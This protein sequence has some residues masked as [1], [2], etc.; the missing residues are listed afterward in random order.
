LSCVG[1]VLDE[2]EVFRKVLGDLL[3][4]LIMRTLGAF[5]I[6]SLVMLL[7]C[8]DGAR[9]EKG[10]AWKDDL[11][12]SIEAFKNRKIYQRLTPEILVSIPDHEL[13]LAIVDYVH[14]KVGRRYDQELQIVGRM[15]E[16]IR[17]VYSTW[18]LEAEVINGGFNQFFW[19]SS[20]KYAAA[21]AAGFAFFELPT[22]ARIVERAIEINQR[23]ASRI[24]KFKQ[25]GSAAAFSQS[26]KDNPLNDLDRE[27]DEAAKNL[28]SMRVAS[29]RKRPEL[30]VG[31]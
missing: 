13:E 29:I 18:L 5:L 4:A 8:G 24:E 3:I 11:A 20:E 23:E 15:S 16:G 10:S 12:K 2:A 14:E 27:F 1:A 30:F 22:L 9:D 19:N 7:S 21:A 26:Y 17:A 25:R 6:A 31:E 28:S